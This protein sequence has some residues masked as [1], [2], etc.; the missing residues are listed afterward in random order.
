M[1]DTNVSKIEKHPRFGDFM[2]LF[3]ELRL[4]GNFT[5]SKLHKAISRIDPN[6]H[7]HNVQHFFSKFQDSF[8]V[9]QEIK[10]AELREKKKIIAND[11]L[12]E[13]AK[14]PSKVPI[15]LRIRLGQEAT[16][17]ELNEVRM[18]LNEKH[19]EKQEGFMEKLLNSARYGDK[20]NVL[21]G[22]VLEEKPM[23]DKRAESLELPNPNAPER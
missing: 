13:V 12:D 10:R 4:N 6:I 22:Q 2:R 5:Y 21:E 1:S 7:Y 9:K 20:D 16:T 11:A 8:L 18:I 17:E 14:N 15:A 3:D 23:L 19:K